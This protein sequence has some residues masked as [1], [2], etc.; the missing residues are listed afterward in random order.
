MFDWIRKWRRP[1]L[2]DGSQYVEDTDSGKLYIEMA[3]HCPDCKT[4]PPRYMAGPSGGLSTN[5]F[6]GDC[7]A[8]YNITPMVEVASPVGR[9]ERYI[10]K[11]EDA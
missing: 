2:A 6:C 8:G 11:K 4:K 1:K 9:N 5:V 10:V 3:K 7:G